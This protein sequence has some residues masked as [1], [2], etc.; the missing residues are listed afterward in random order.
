MVRTRIAH[1]EKHFTSGNFVRDVVIGM[2]DGLTVPFALAA[3]L[4]GAVAS[5]RLIVVGGMAEIAAGSIAMGL[6]GYLAARGDAE[7]YE[8]ERARECR[9]IKEIP[10]E[11]V[12]EVKGVFQSYGLPAEESQR[13]AE[14]L[15]HHPDAWV[16]FMMRFEL[17]LEEPDPK[18]A[19]NSAGTIAGAYIAGG[20]IPLSPYIVLSSAYRG[21]IFSAAVTLA[22]LAVFG[23]IKGRFTGARAF[24]SALQTMVI[25]G[26][27]AAAAFGLARLIA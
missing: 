19:V 10:E 9:E 27:A 22:A 8:Q 24:R 2:S 23:F 15:S 26:V 1:T 12:A 13:V 3:G 20:L 4:S 5:T 25:G 14:E 7:H 11:E 6:G 21:L 17:G 18:R 16:D